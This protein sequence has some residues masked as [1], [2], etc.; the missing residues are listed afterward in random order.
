MKKAL[1]ILIVIFTYLNL[2]AQAKNQSQ[3]EKSDSDTLVVV[4]TSGDIEVAE[5]VCFMYTHN[6]KKWGWFK[7]VVLIVWGPSANLLV[8]NSKLEA[9]VKQMATDGIKLEACKACSD[10][11]GVSEKL[12]DIGVDVKYMGKQ[13]TKYLKGNYS[14]ISF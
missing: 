1:I 12:I 3:T 9:Q 6:A 11:Y 13:L 10:S 5:N 7:N 4:W 14:V 8:A 2:F